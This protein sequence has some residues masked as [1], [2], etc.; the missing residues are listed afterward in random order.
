MLRAILPVGVES[1]PLQAAG[2]TYRRD[3]EDHADG[4]AGPERGCQPHPV[5]P[6]VDEAVKEGDEEDEE[7]DVEERQ[8]RHGDLRQNTSTTHLHISF[9]FE[10]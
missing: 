3:G 6:G 2:G 4:D 8:P 1:V 9:N 10:C 5:Q 7:E